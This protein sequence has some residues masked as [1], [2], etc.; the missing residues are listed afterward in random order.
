MVLALFALYPATRL[1]WPM[2]LQLAVTTVFYLP[3]VPGP[4]PPWTR[5]LHTA[6]VMGLVP[7]IRLAA[8]LAVLAL[9]MTGAWQ[10][11]RVSGPARPSVA[12]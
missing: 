8:L 4:F 10:A 11:R 7:G 1:D 12:P 6:E 5:G 2:L 9:C 3:G